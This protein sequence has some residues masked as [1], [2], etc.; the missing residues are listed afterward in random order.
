M[1]SQADALAV[2]RS[3]VND[4]E[5]NKGFG[6]LRNDW[7]GGRGAGGHASRAAYTTAG[8]QRLGVIQRRP[9]DASIRRDMCPSAGGS[10][11]SNI[12]EGC[13][14]INVDGGGTGDP[15]RAGQPETG[16]DGKHCFPGI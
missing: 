2:I 10:C 9:L 7:N 12:G 15:D 4:G 5:A 16:R 8:R 3:S 1:T 6:G 13:I 14:V 11:S